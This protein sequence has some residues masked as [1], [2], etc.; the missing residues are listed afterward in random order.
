MSRTGPFVFD[1][2]ADARILGILE[3]LNVLATDLLA[4]RTAF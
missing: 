4:V 2:M 1:E 3:N